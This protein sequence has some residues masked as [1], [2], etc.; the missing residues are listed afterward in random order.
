MA[1]LPG[2]TWVV[3]WGYYRKPG[4]LVFIFTLLCD[5]RRNSP[6]RYLNELWGDN[7]P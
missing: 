2:K 1:D 6:K 5:L 7:V 3:I 4:M